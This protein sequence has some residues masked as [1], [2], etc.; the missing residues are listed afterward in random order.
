MTN[1]DQDLPLDAA[2]MNELERVTQSTVS[3]LSALGIDLDG[4]ES[5]AQIAR[6]ADAI[7]RFE[8][9]VEAAGGDLMVDEPPPGS[10]GQPDNPDFVL[11]RR[12]ADE[13]IAAYVARI[14]NATARIA[15]E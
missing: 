7:E 4:T 6:I 3:R 1:P 14:E 9:A 5:P 12:A 13:S 10:A 11:P 2:R 8:D 15:R